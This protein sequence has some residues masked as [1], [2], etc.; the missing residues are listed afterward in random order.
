[1]LTL[2]LFLLY[3]L[4]IFV[5]IFAIEYWQGMPKS[6]F[7][8][9]FTLFIGCIPLFNVYLTWKAWENRIVDHE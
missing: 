6:V 2:I 9:Y 8:Q 5:Y 4:S 7:G 3:I 1:M